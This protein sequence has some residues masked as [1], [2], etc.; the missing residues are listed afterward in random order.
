MGFG[1]RDPS[2]QR[3]QK[4]KNHC[5]SKWRNVQYRIQGEIGRQNDALRNHSFVE[6]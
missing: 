5:N 6:A 1:A 2:R 3:K 4:I